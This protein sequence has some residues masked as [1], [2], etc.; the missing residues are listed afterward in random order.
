MI[1]KAIQNMRTSRDTQGL[2]PKARLAILLESLA[3]EAMPSQRRWVASE[4]VFYELSAY[5]PL[6]D[7]YTYKKRHEWYAPLAIEVFVH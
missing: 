1:D 5:M 7:C 2:L 3:S 6:M 4:S